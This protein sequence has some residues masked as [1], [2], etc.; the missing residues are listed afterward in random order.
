MQQQSNPIQEKPLLTVCLITYN[1]LAFIEQAIKSILAQKTNFYFNVI[2]ADDCSKDGTADIV[3]EYAKNYPEIISVILQNPNVGAGI[4]Y[5]QLIAAA[6]GKYIAYLEGDD[7]W[8]DHNKLQEQINILESNPDYVSCFTNVLETFSENENDKNNFLQNGCYPK[9]IIGFN[10]L[11]YK[12]YIQ[13]CSIVFRNYL[14]TPFPEWFIKLKVGDWPLHILLSQYGTSF[15][16]NKPMAVHRNH[17][18]GAWS[19]K[20]KLER[21]EATLEAYNAIQAHTKL[22]NSR[23]YDKAKSNVL[24]SSVKYCIRE[25]KIGKAFKYFL[26]GF[27]LFPANLYQK[28]LPF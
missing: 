19:N 2:I 22:A 26:K 13:T 14:V 7:Y 9:S 11:I 8:T 17:S 6:T 20:T 16:I 3:K 18:F 21:I 4:N 1:H 24:L 28:K 10:E 5:G 23:H 27:I 25:K 12:N 15:Y